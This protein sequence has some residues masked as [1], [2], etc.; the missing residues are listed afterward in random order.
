MVFG[1]PEKTRSFNRTGAAD[2]SLDQSASPLLNQSV[3][4]NNP[5]DNNFH[6]DTDDADGEKQM[7]PG[8]IVHEYNIVKEMLINNSLPI[9][10]GSID[11]N[12]DSVFSR[13]LIIDKKIIHNLL[14]DL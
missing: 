4:G 2:K 7:S 1:A 11:Q 6:Q 10:Q 8:D 12:Q 14:I 13:K 9:S 5:Q 3:A